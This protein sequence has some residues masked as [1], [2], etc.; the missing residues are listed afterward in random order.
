M[1][2]AMENAGAKDQKNAKNVS[3][4]GLISSF[5]FS[6]REKAM[7]ASYIRRIQTRLRVAFVS[8]FFG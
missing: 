1:K 5:S 3:S 7:E 4:Y 8:K 2:V 6:C